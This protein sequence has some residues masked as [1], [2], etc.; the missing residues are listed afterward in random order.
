MFSVFCFLLCFDSD[1]SP[2]FPTHPCAKI[3]H[4][5][6]TR[7]IIVKCF[8]RI[9]R[10]YCEKNQ[11]NA[12]AL[13]NY[14]HFKKK[15]ELKKKKKKIKDKQEKAK[16][17]ITEIDGIPINKKDKGQDKVKTKAKDVIPSPLLQLMKETGVKQEIINDEIEETEEAQEENDEEKKDAN[18]PKEDDDDDADEEEK[19]AEDEE[20]EEDEEE[21]EHHDPYDA[22]DLDEFDEA[23]SHVIQDTFVDG[24]AWFESQGLRP[25]L[26]EKDQKMK[27][28]KEKK[29]LEEEERRK[30]KFLPTEDKK[31]DIDANSMSIEAKN[32]EDMLI[33]KLPPAKSS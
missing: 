12:G 2:C 31:D 25:E 23:C 13:V 8:W 33:A 30:H 26:E 19:D 27:E 6:R 17:K 29:K 4:G 18:Y 5:A 32:K 11:R 22:E 24:I 15:E 16:M 10:P 7:A 20:D 14:Q 3:K 21:D 9:A 1:E 28:D